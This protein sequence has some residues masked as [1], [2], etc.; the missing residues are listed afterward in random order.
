ML[1]RDRPA[2]TA[3]FGGPMRGGPALFV[4]DAV[5]EELLL[6]VAFLIGRG[7][8]HFLRIMVANEAAHL[9]PERV[10]VPRCCRLG[11]ACIHFPDHRFQLSSKLELTDPAF[12]PFSGPFFGSSHGTFHILYRKG[13][14]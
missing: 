9:L 6:L 8:A 11:H 1:L 7:D 2:R 12:K 5:P 14:V 10:V 13:V 4:E 3:I